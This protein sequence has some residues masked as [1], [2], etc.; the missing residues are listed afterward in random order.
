MCDATRLEVLPALL[1]SLARILNKKHVCSGSY[2]IA[3]HFRC[4][5][6]ITGG[7]GGLGGGQ[8]RRRMRRRI[9]GGGGGLDEEEK[10]YRRRR[11]RGKGGG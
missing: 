8:G 11:I 1:P 4:V 5:D 6:Y 3:M 9:R 7:G 10:D 2:Q